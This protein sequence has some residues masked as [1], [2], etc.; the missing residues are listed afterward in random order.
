MTKFKRRF[1]AMGISAAMLLSTVSMAF[2]AN[3][4]SVYEESANI[5]QEYGVMKGDNGDLML[6]SQLKRQDAIIISLR[7]MGIT[8]EEFENYENSS[9]FTDITD[10]Y[11]LPI[12]G[13]A[14]DLGLVEGMGDGTFGFNNLI[15]AQDVATLLLR[16]LGYEITDEIYPTVSELAKEIGVLNQIETENDTLIT[17]D[18]VAQ[19]MLNTLNTNVK[20]GEQTLG[21]M[22]GYADPETPVELEA[23]EISAKVATEDSLVVTFNRAVEDTSALSFELKGTSTV[24]T[25]VAWNEAKTEATLTAPSVLLEGAYTVTVSGDTFAE[26][27]NVT[28]INV[29]ENGI[30]KIEILGGILVL[31]DGSDADDTDADDAGILAYK[32]YDKYGVDI[33]EDTLDSELQIA[34]SKTNSGFAIDAEKG[35]MQIQFNA[36]AGTTPLEKD[37]TVAVTIISKDSGAAVSATLT[38]VEESKVNE[39][40]LSGI[41][42]EDEDT[43]KILTGEA[44]AAYILMDAVDQY[45]IS[46]TS[47]TDLL[48]D[49]SGEVL[50]VVSDSQVTITAEEYTDDND[51]E[52]A[53]LIVDTTGLSVEKTVT[54]TAVSKLSGKSASIT[55]DIKEPAKPAKV[56]VGA[57]EGLVAASDPADTFVLPI[58]VLDQDGVQL[59]QDEIAAKASDFT[60]SAT[61]ALNGKLVIATSGENKGKIINNAQLGA[62]DGTAVITVSTSTDVATYTVNVNEVAYEKTMK[63]DSAPAQNLLMGATTEMN[64]KFMDQYGREME[65]PAAGTK[66]TIEVSDADVLLGTSTSGNTGANN[67]YNSNAQEL[68]ADDALA[69]S[70][71]TDEGTAKVTAKLYNQAGDA[72]ISKVET[73]ISV[74]DGVPGTLTFEIEDIANLPSL[75]ADGAVDG[76][77]QYARS[78]KLIAKDA[79]GK[80]FAIP[81]DRILSVSTVDSDLI[82]LS[83]AI[84]SGAAIDAQDGHYVVAAQDE[85]TVAFDTTE[86]TKTA[87]IKFVIS[88]DDGVREVTK[89]VTVA[90]EDPKVASIVFADKALNANNPYELDKDAE[91][92]TEISGTTAD[93]N[94]QK[95]YVYELDQYGVYTEVA[96]PTFTVVNM[97]RFTNSIDYASNQLV[98]NKDQ[99]ADAENVYVMYQAANGVY[100]TFT[101]NASDGV[102]TLDKTAPTLTSAT[103]IDAT[104]LRLVFNQAVTATAANFTDGKFVDVSNANAA[105]TFTV[106]SLAGSGTATITLTITGSVAIETGDTG[107]VDISAAVKDLAGNAIVAIGD[108]VVALF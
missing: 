71:V 103:F 96:A 11:Y 26:G 28:T 62:A 27:K 3:D 24:E 92:I 2:A 61:G 84:V 30:A 14:Q 35:K 102:D 91:V 41:E 97:D 82:I 79:N 65:S 99:I 45:G 95:L 36:A 75:V 59:T 38:A 6:G 15:K 77:D 88:T 47:A 101:L 46:I 7:L 16:A 63:L 34:T 68:S 87:T 39:I 72:V 94:A 4:T 17:R 74:T 8:D 85:A 50:Y 22:L 21:E 56:S 25:E 89:E 81:T 49:G 20:D 19:M 93:I 106:D 57:L 23:L 73:S 53:R 5:L 108:Q 64:Y 80:T 33:T 100:G 83:N 40:A 43:T 107:T 60:I 1:I 44:N 54:V 55:L 32:L 42:F 66:V 29:I 13:M 10:S 69:I 76:S 105:E 52:K 98:F 18:I 9:N 58:V 78:I 67:P 90:K 12:I 31:A 51:V 104:T 37:D 48:E 70:T 86:E